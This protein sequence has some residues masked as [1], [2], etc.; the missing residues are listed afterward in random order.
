MLKLNSD[1]ESISN[2]ICLSHKQD[3]LPKL[4]VWNHFSI[5]S[6]SALQIHK[7]LQIQIRLYKYRFKI[8]VAVSKAYIPYQM[9]L[10][11]NLN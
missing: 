6:Y 4:E 1:W 10:H 11:R 3:P 7:A 2:S 5:H 8:L 9:N